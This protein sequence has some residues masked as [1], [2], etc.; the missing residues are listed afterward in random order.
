MERVTSVKNT[1]VRNLRSLK[2][3]K[4][5]ESSGLILVEGE[6]MILEAL[7]CGLIPHD[8]LTDEK[9]AATAEKVEAAGGRGLIVTREVL[10]AVCETKT[11]QGICASFDT[12]KPVALEMLKGAVVALD[13]VQ[14]PGNVG[15]IWRTADAAG[16]GGI[17]FCEG[18]ADP[19]S[20]KVLRSAMGS[21]FRL[22]FARVDTMPEALEALKALGKTVIV[23]DLSGSDFYA[24]ERLGT[25]IVLVIGNEAHGISDAVRDTADK[26][27][28]LPMHGGAESLN[29]AIA[30]GILMY[31]LMNEHH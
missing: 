28:K 31:D 26:R 3:R 9:H 24:R 7:A 15:T 4:Y 18:C 5:R 19:M 29:A 21:G 10:E 25:D 16:F 2:D 8:V 14:D 11:P 20:P 1:T 27:Y 30:A 6:V 12:P 23:S 22:P 17:V 13:R